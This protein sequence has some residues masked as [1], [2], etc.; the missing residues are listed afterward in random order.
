MSI[1]FDPE[2]HPP[3]E[4]VTAWGT[5]I[6]FSSAFFPK[7]M[8]TRYN[9]LVLL[10]KKVEAANDKINS[11]L[12]RLGWTRTDLMEWQKQQNLTRPKRRNTPSA[13][14]QSNGQSIK[15]PL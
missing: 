2:N 3:N 7:T 12:S 1:S 8:D 4:T 13:K 14:A 6:L 11:I 9:Q 15:I 10:S 5:L